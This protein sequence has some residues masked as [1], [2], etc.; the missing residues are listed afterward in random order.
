[1]V[2]TK[3]TAEGPL[4]ADVVLVVE[5]LMVGI[6]LVEDVKAV[7]RVHEIKEL[8][9]SSMRTSHAHPKDFDCAHKR[10]NTVSPK[11]RIR[12]IICNKCAE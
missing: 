4:F 12:L 9:K 1:L 2:I 11:S 7:S 10:S 3:L 8:A 5:V 6:E